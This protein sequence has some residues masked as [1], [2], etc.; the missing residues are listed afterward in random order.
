MSDGGCVQR[1][2]RPPRKLRAV[3]GSV[4]PS[5]SLDVPIETK[6]HAP[7]ARAEW[8][9]RRG[10]VAHLTT[11]PA[12]LVLVEAPAGFGKTTLVAQWRASP[13]E[14]RPFAWL[15]LDPGDDDPARLW[16]HVTCALLRACP[17]LDCADVQRALRAQ[18]PDITGTV[19][20]MLINALAALPGELVLVLDD[21]HLIRDRDCLEQTASF[22]VHL[23][24]TVQLVVIT[25]ATPALPLARLRAGGDM[26]EIGMRELRFAIPD[27]GAFL[28][29][30]TGIE[31]SRPDLAQ[32]VD[33]TEGWPA[34]VYL[35]AL[36][37]R[38]HPEPSAFIREF[39]G[40]NRFIMDFLAEE[41]LGR[42][43]AGIRQFLARTSLLD[44][45][46]AP[47][48]DAVTGSAD[49]A[50][51]IDV[52]EREN[53]FVVPLDETRQW[54]R[55][56]HLFAEVLRT[57]LISTEADLVPVLH[58]RASAWHRAAGSVGDAVGHALA[59]RDAATAVELI[60]Q[61]WYA[62]VNVGWTGTVGGWLGSLS[63]EQIAANPLAAHCAA[64]AAALSGEPEPVRRWLPVIEGARHDGMLPDGIRSMASSAALLRGV[65]GFD[66]LDIMRQ[67][68]AAAVG[69]EDDPA[70]AWYTLARATYG[71]CLYLSGEFEAAL[72]PLEQATVSAGAD[73]LVGVLAYSVLA[74]VSLEQGRLGRARELAAVA[75]RLAAQ[76]ELAETPQSSMAYTAT[77]AVYA[78]EG[79]LKDSRSELRR[80]V[81][82]RRRFPGI[83]PWATLEA[84]LRLAGVLLAMGDTQGAAEL[85]GEAGRVLT[86][87]PDGT[88]YLEA[89]LGRL[90]RQLAPERRPGLEDSLT[91]REED[92]LRLL[93]GTLSL[94]EISQQLY[95]SPNTVKTH[96]QAIYR[97]LGV[98]SRHEAV[99]RG[100]DIGVL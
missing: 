62:Y 10:L 28:H 33:R 25:R 24:V 23:P 61:H 72:L 89:R 47:L 90:R 57:E 16:W 3:G 74:L 21:Y 82:V 14:R 91:G 4:H 98:S 31:L 76:D 41:V 12:K 52:L 68:A 1:I 100:R 96:A 56:H 48:C 85:A 81:R 70:S 7:G 58:R 87:F 66:G 46:C 77:G 44:R 79:R 92:V 39:T 53:L 65:Y 97:K 63:E 83:S 34:G 43:P 84:S 60:A 30:V 86:L 78:A 26:V 8:V 38:S 88:G 71:F 75:R 20:P 95:V 13:T 51:I 35:A 32:L 59:A 9:P 49:A 11:T 18:R 22:L 55:Y 45:F 94:R 27:A 15:S 17:D 36:S 42:Q 40:D 54:F 93:R 5:P 50:G 80:A 73:T 37:L 6:L 29:A 19:L 99:Q 69:I 64:W 2:D 67:S